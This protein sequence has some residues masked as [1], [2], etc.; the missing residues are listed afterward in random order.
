ME[1]TNN[2]TK[3]EAIA[4]PTKIQELGIENLIM[5]GVDV[6]RLYKPLYEALKDGFQGS[7]LFA[8]LSQYPL[9]QHIAGI[10]KPAFAEIRELSASEAKQ[11]SEAI[12]QQTGLPN[13]RSLLGKVKTG[14]ALI[15]RTYG[16]VDD[17]KTVAYEWKN[18]FEADPKLLDLEIKPLHP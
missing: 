15:S 8:I 16:V 12:A 3:Y 18:L 5:L 2:I 7:D 10:A 9:I 13:D 4:R 17:A 14:L 6:L 11:L 1:S